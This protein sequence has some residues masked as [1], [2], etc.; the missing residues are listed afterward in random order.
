MMARFRWPQKVAS[1]RMGSALLSTMVAMFWQTS[2]RAA[3]P[4]GQL[5]IQAPPALRR[6]AV[7]VD[8]KALGA[9]PQNQLLTLPAGPHKLTVSEG[10]W[11]LAAEFTM[12]AGQRVILRWPTPGLGKARYLPTV[13][14]L[15]EPE[16]ELPALRQAAV[17]SIHR[18]R[19]AV[20]GEYGTPISTTRHAACG[21][22]LSCLEE[23]AEAH[24]LRHVLSVQAA[25]VDPHGFRLSARLFDAETAD[26]SAQLSE[27]CAACTLAAA[28]TRLAALCSR[29][30]KLGMQRPLGLLEVNSQP[31]G[32]EVL[33]DGRRVGTTPYLRS[34]G[35]GEHEVVVHKTGFLD[36]QNTVDVLANRGSALD[37]ILRPDTASAQAASASEGFPP[38][39]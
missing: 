12:R 26:L 10:R 39:R 34:A 25:A 6:G 13:A 24:G 21:E 15:M 14:L 38:R 18:G 1:L 23:L 9:L 29:V 20:L 17:D 8:G 22:T 16:G 11:R 31:S 19:F 35:P 30:L 28:R 2:L 4:S 27:D 37:A 7:E 32:A 3:A 33:V 5:L 36:Y